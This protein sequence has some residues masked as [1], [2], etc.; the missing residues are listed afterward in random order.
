MFSGAIVAI[1]TPF[2]EGRLDEEAYRGLI[3]WQIANG[4]SAIVP[5]GTTGESPTLS[6]EEHKRVIDVCIDQVKGRVPVIAGTGGNSTAEAVELTD[7]ARA[8]GADASLQVVPY[9]NKPTQEGLYLHFARIAEVGLPLILYNIPGRTG[10]NMLPETVGRLSK[11]AN[12]V[13]IKEASG[14]LQQMAEVVA[15]CGEGFTLLS[16]D[17]T[18]VLPVMAIGGKGVISVVSNVAPRLM[19]DLCAAYL[20]GDNNLARRLYYKMLPLAQA[21]FYETNPVPVKAALGMMGKC[22]P[23]CRLPLAPMNDSAKG[24]LEVV[25]RRQGLIN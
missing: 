13:G 16:G 1:V 18:I 12:V 8:A 4:T 22:G 20:S 3:D 21:M 14:N 2:R 9:Y 25:L 5:C 23:E 15:A 19:S 17:D 10:V 24:K 11:L 7:H 6:F